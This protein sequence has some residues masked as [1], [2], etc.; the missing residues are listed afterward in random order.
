MSQE[1]GSVMTFKQVQVFPAKGL[2]LY[3]TKLEEAWEG[4]R[5]VQFLSP[6]RA[7]GCG[8]TVVLCIDTHTHI[9]LMQVF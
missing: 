6:G 2:H 1:L 5:D 9:V 8:A 7:A 3:M 4:R